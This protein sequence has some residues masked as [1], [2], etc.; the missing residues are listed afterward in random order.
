MRHS[1]LLTVPPAAPADTSGR[2]VLRC[3][4]IVSY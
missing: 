2:S 1:S 3:V 4:L